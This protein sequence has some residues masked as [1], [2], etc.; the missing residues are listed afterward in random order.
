MKLVSV[1]LLLST[2][3]YAADAET[4]TETEKRLE[5]IT[6]KTI[7]QSRQTDGVGSP[8]VEVPISEKQKKVSFIPVQTE[9]KA[10]VVI[11]AYETIV[12]NQ[13]PMPLEQKK[14]CCQRVVAVGIGV[15]VVVKNRA[16]N[17]L[18]SIDRFVPKYKN[19]KEKQ[20]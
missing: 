16:I 1:C 17:L 4:Q 12:V 11:P 5:D 14:D 10:S 19:T 6:I 8:F 2:V 9:P 15:I 7:V 13:P 20:Q 3:C 18:G